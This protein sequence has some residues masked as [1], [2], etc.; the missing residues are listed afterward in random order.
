[1]VNLVNLPLAKLNQH[2]IKLVL[3]GDDQQPPTSLRAS[4]L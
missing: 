3:E 1:M 4:E 2:P